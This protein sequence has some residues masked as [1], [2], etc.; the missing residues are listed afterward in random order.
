MAIGNWI[1]R[2]AKRHPEKVGVV[3]EGKRYT[4]GEINERVNRLC[5]A[6]KRLGLKKGDR[7]G[8]LLDNCNQFVEAHG[9]CAKGGMV[10][11]P[12][13]TRL[14]SGELAYI[15]NNAEASAVIFGATYADTIGA[16]RSKCE[17][18]H[19]F[20]MVEGEAEG[21]DA[22]DELL[23]LGSPEEPDVEVGEEDLLY[24]AYTSGTTGLP[25]GAM[26][27]HRNHF[28]STIDNVIHYRIHPGSKILVCLPMFFQ[29]TV[30]CALMPCF[31]LGATM[32]IH[33]GFEAKMVLETIEKEKITFTFLA[34]S[35]IIFLLE[36]PDINKYD[37]S[38]LEVLMYGS[39]PMPVAKLKEAMKIFNC[40]FVQ[41]H[42]FTEY[43]CCTTS[44]EPEDHV[45]EGPAE[46]VKRIASC[47]KEMI[48]VEARVVNE[49]SE[50]VKPGEV[51]ELVA[52]GEK[53]MQGYW[54]NPEATAEAIDKD[55]WLHS[56]DMATLDQEGY[57]YIVDRKKDMIISGGINIYPKEIEEIL[58]THPAVLE[59][60]VIG[61]PDDRWGESVMAV[62]ALK[63][64]MKAT[65]EEIINHC[66]EHLASYKKPKSVYF[67]ERLPR[68][69][70]G[71][72]LK[73][74]LREPYWKG[75]DRKV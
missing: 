7:L 68:N 8:V 35:P 56:G 28:Y 30:G 5:N 47:G 9:A 1:T 52:R 3:F 69:P 42:G 63:E 21:V 2:N 58:F 23:A 39:A 61:I 18:T 29:A 33:R 20:I 11:V 32:V 15:I 48:N 14:L 73:R 65:E 25:K 51:G 49:K 57:V 54:K 55:G 59:A 62:V 66:K 16:L 43:T 67:V 44:L 70:G 71:K 31:Y 34:P 27:T 75:R 26:I 19:H 36:E 24:I 41:S 13:N 6:L 10:L 64:A 74:E 60:A 53:V 22:Y 17:S 40:K 72:V 38:S 12:L 46:K 45:L 50:D 37:Y 4:F